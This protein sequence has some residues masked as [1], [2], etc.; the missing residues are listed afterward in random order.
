MQ[1]DIQIGEKVI[2]MQANAA[3]SL[4]YREIFKEDLLVRLDE[5]KNDLSS[6]GNI[7][8]YERLGYIMAASAA[9]EDM[10]TLSQDG[11]VK[12]LEGFEFIDIINAAMDIMN[13]YY[14]NK[15]TKSTAK[16]KDA[17]QSGK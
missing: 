8:L 1:R 12:W 10:K 2:P 16:K 15:E 14:G 7:E 6:Y 13:T 11:F 17:G 5:A 3:T 4:R 9:G